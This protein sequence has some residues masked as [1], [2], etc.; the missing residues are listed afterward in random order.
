MYGNMIRLVYSFHIMT[1]EETI[2][3]KICREISRTTITD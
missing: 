3:V 2:C 1:A